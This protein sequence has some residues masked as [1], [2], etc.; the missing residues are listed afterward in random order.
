VVSNVS[1]EEGSIVQR[2]TSETLANIRS[3]IRGIDIGEHANEPVCYSFTCI[4]VFTNIQSIQVLPVD[5]PS[6]NIDPGIY[7]SQEN[8][9][10]GGR[11]L[12]AL[13]RPG[14]SIS[15]AEEYSTRRKFAAEDSSAIERLAR[16]NLLLGDGNDWFHNAIKPS[17]AEDS[18]SN[19]EEEMWK[20]FDNK[21]E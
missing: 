21:A 14:A 5:V 8:A 11:I 2:F 7:T 20:M 16:T 18:S 9:M 19:K 6:S 1:T 12:T 13:P 15:L 10:M 17:Q 3:W 4:L